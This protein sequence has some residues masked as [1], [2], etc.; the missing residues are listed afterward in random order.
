MGSKVLNQTITTA[1]AEI[2][3]VR[4]DAVT[5]S[6]YLR[7]TAQSSCDVIYNI[8]LDLLASDER[9]GPG[10]WKLVFRKRS[11]KRGRP[12]KSPRAISAVQAIASGQA[13]IAGQYL[14]AKP[15]I[16]NKTQSALAAAFDL[17]GSST[18]ILRFEHPKRGYP[19]SSLRTE[20]EDSYLGHH[21]LL[22]YAE[23]K[24]WKQIYYKIDDER[25][26]ANGH[27]SATLIKRAVAK[28]RNARKRAAAAETS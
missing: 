21:A 6:R 1:G 8:A 22:L 20:L 15:N 17:S 5:L 25:R 7:Q 12:S 13:V 10:N 3:C 16:D 24:S 4:G 18:W 11:K 27:A 19:Q 26:L 23:N 9:P 14:L 28:V 2:A